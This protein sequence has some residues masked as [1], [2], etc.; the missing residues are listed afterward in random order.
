MGKVLCD[1]KSKSIFLDESFANTE[2]ATKFFLVIE[3]STSKSCK[4][5]PMDATLSKSCLALPKSLAAPMYNIF[6]SEL[7]VNW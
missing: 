1:S 7:T 6:G 4:G 3:T 2:E 5:V